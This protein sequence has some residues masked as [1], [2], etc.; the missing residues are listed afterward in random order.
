[1]ILDVDKINT[2]YGKSQVLFDLSLEVEEGEVVTVLGRNGVG[3][4]TALRSVMGINPPRSG[5]IRFNDD[6]ITNLEP[7]QIFQRGIGYV[8]QGREVFGDLTVVENLQITGRSTDNGDWSMA[9]VFELFPEIERR[10]ENHADTLSGGEQQMLA[11]GRALM[12]DPNLLLLD[13]P[14]EGLAPTIIEN[15]R[16]S[17]Q[18]LR[19][20]GHTILLVEQN[21]DMAMDLGDRHYVVNEGQNVFEGST[22]ELKESDV[23]DQYLTV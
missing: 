19:A 23:I 18:E 9:D 5:R 17:I 10:K 12:G 14:S 22:E 2:F 3:K 20:A 6:E 4:T 21:L 13:E 11:I 15:I 7:Y 8:P 16:E 1:M